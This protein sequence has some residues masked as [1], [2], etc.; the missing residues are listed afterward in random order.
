M[1]HQLN[2]RIFNLINQFAGQNNF[3][4]NITIGVAKYMPYIFILVLLYLW[5]KKDNKTKNITLYASYSAI[6]GILLNFVIALFYFHPRPF[7]DKVG[8]ILIDHTPETSFP[9]DHTTFMLALSFM[10]LSFKET[11]NIGIILSILGILGGISRIY[12]GVHYPFDI[13]GSFL[14]AMFSS[15][16]IFLFRNKLQGLNNFIINLYCKLLK[17]E[18]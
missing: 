16:I 11:R 17:W 13:F 10:F 1:L 9:S 18:K 5:F 2:V 3:L 14:I 8:T 7:M 12:C 4:D 15:Y 6:L